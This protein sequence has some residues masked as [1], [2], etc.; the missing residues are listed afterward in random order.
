M[1]MGVLIS[2]LIIIAGSLNNHVIIAGSLNNHVIIAGL[3]Y[4][5]ITSSFVIIAGSSNYHFSLFIIQVY[6]II[7]TEKP[8]TSK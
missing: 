5:I 6:Y 8:F 1:R 7:I 2:Y 4:Q 3:V